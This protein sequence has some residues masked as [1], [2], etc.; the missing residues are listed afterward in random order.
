MENNKIKCLNERCIE[1]KNP[2]KGNLI[3]KIL[4]EDNIGF[5]GVFERFISKP[6]IYMDNEYRKNHP[7][8]FGD[9]RDNGPHLAFIISAAT[10]I[11][12][13]KEFSGI[14]VPRYKGEFRNINCC[15]QSYFGKV[16]E[17]KV[18]IHGGELTKGESLEFM[19]TNDLVESDSK[20]FPY[21][22]PMPNFEEDSPWYVGKEEICKELGKRKKFKYFV[23]FVK[24]MDEK[25]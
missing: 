12:P 1:S 10:E 21:Y 8:R 2:K 4:D 3:L 13:S 5:L 11:W 24:K 22:K 19:K 18:L 7:Y 25:I 16:S 9:F 23:D 17:S 14:Q 6:I 20:F 15:L